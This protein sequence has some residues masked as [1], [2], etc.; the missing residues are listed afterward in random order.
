MN[1]YSTD[2][3][4]AKI[5][6]IM[7]MG[8]ATAKESIRALKDNDGDVNRAMARLY[9]DTTYKNE[10]HY[11]TKTSRSKHSRRHWDEESID[12]LPDKGIA[13][14]IKEE[15]VASKPQSQYTPSVGM[16]AISH[17]NMRGSD[18]P[19]VH[20]MTA[21]NARFNEHSQVYPGAVAVP[22]PGGLNA[23]ND[24]DDLATTITTAPPGDSI[25]P[26]SARVVN[27]TEEDYERLQE[28]LRQQGKQLRQVLADREHVAFAEVIGGDEEAQAGRERGQHQPSP[29]LS[30]RKVLFAAVFAILLAVVGVV[31]YFLVFK[32]PPPRPLPPQDLVDL[33]SSASL[34]G[35]AALLTPSTPQN[36]ALYW[37][38]DNANLDS[39]SN[40]KKIQRFVL[41]TLYYSTRGYLW[42]NNT[43]WL[44]DADE[45]TNWFNTAPGSFCSSGAV[46]DLEIDN[47][48]LDGR[49]PAEVALLSNSMRRMSLEYNHL[50]GTILSE[51][52][53][54]TTLE[55]LR[56]QDNKL[57]GV[58]IPPEFARLTN[59]KALV[60]QA[61]ALTGRMLSSEIGS[62]TSLTA[63]F[64]VFNKLTGT[65]PSE[66][67]LMTNL[68]AV[69]LAWNELTGTI[70]THIGL[71]TKL[72]LLELHH[73]DLS[74]Q[75]TCPVSIPTCLVSCD[76]VNDTAC[77]FL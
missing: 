9:G 29:I 13:S 17:D 11:E 45:C 38:A 62:M 63:L 67:G 8:R 1:Q 3:T 22:G 50:T 6:L 20:R 76:N 64:L 10:P 28:Q 61:N 59:L 7:S 54:L 42:Q 57:S 16:M 27:E 4:D 18:E 25:F 14:I 56:L 5:A 34:D 39:Y 30:R 52:G 69:H 43:G 32:P 70:P 71:L 33:L 40:V 19:L 72:T 35:G 48:T 66:I 77:R 44:S 58:A 74:G 46:S 24:L 73:N 2:D 55:E 12:D 31:V 37:L 49:I 21:A 26:V 65:I 15:R 47:N 36:D 41:A 75:F 51:I 53:L 60:L 68:D 23:A